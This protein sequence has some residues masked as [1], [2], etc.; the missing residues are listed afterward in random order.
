MK[1]NKNSSTKTLPHVYVI[2]FFLILI[3]CILTYVIPA[4]EFERIQDSYTG[5]T[6]VVA[7]S[8][9]RTA[10]NPVEVWRIPSKLFEALINK[11]T[12][13]LIFFILIIGGSFEII[14]QTGSIVAFFNKILVLFKNKRIYII[15]LFVSLFSVLGFTV[16]LTT[17]SIIFVPIGILAARMLGF[18]LLTGTAMVALGANAGFAAGIFNPFT[19]GIAQTMAEVPLYSGAWMRWIL[20]VCLVIAT[21]IYIMHYAKNHDKNSDIDQYE[22]DT[23]LNDIEQNDV[24]NLNN[25]IVLFIFLST[26][27][28]ITYAA[29]VYNWNIDNIAALFLT[30]SIL[31]GFVHGFKANQICNIFVTG[32]KKM[33]TGVFVIGLAATMRL[34]L[35]EGQ[36]LDTIAYFLI[37]PISNA[38]NWLK[39]M[40][41][42]YGNAALDFLITSGT[43]HSSVVI[44]I[45][46]PMTDYFG[47]SRQSC[48]FA[49]QLGDGLVNLCSPLSTTLTGILAVSNISYGKWVKFF[50]PLVGIYLV[51][52]TAFILFASVVGY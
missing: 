52:G 38:P 8:Y 30:T 39:L 16:G 12:A 21:N 50:Y 42:F 44:P 7:E 29:S 41:M 40:S 5:R 4:G 32:C 6:I 47:I 33:M 20:L 31:S 13:R 23:L 51:I 10:S 2:L 9:E 34:I 49:F 14:M 18:D 25:K 43:A 15:P 11:T 17:T 1:T 46:I 36:I 3:C 35:S 24:L 45:M 19:V 28:I 48:V 37:K 27:V 22:I 26:F